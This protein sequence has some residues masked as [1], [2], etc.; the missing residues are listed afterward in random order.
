[1]K[2]L[3][4]NNFV[5]KRKLTKRLKRRSFAC[6]IQDE[7]IIHL[8]FRLSYAS[9]FSPFI[10]F[11]SANAQFVCNLMNTKETRINDDVR[12]VSFVKIRSVHT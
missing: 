2:R 1:M 7:T 10:G 4:W 6:E 5:S 9:D 8:S 3:H 12:H 11:I